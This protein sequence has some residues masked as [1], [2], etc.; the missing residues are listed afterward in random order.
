MDDFGNLQARRFRDTLENP[1]QN[2]R[3]GDQL[4]PENTSSI[5]IIDLDHFKA[6]NDTNGHLAGDAVLKTVAGVLREATRAEDTAARPGGDEFVVLFN[7]AAPEQVRARLQEIREKVALTGIPI[8]LSVGMSEID[9]QANFEEA[10]SQAD[11]AV[12][13]AKEN[14]RDNI[15]VFMPVKQQ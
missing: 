7:N 2:R 4:Q 5:A 1:N 10:F 11:Q 12:Y 6:V 3:A 14:G 9:P 8:T 15:V 13:A